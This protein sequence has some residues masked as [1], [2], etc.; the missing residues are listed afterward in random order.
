MKIDR[1]RITVRDLIDGYI[2]KGENGI[3]GVVAY[4]GKLDVRP[5]YQREYVYSGK[6]RDE[7][8]RSILKGFPI[9]VMYWSK[10]G[11][12]RYELMDGQQRTVS[13]CRYAAESERTFAVNYKY[14]FNLTQDEQDAVLNYPL[15][16]Y[17][18]DGSPSEVLSWFKVINI[19]GV[20]LSEQEL[21]NTSYT[22]AWLSDAKIHFSKPNCAAYHMAK[23]YVSVL[24]SGRNF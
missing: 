1:I 14:F 11:D 6:D 21:R 19:A 10:V 9:N 8:I 13:I 7:V 12:D 20:K 2:E 18:C 16:V 4:G 3:E 15:D 22:G 5:A 24:L 23:D 17:V